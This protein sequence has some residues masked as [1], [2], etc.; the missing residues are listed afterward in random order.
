MSKQIQIKKAEI[1]MGWS[2]EAADF[3]NKLIQ[4]KPGSRLGNNGPE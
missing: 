3:C 2:I 1:P 4:R